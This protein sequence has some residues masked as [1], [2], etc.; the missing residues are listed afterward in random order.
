[1]NLTPEMTTA[2][3]KLIAEIGPILKTMDV[4]TGGQNSYRAVSDKEVKTKVG[5]ALAT[6]GF[7]IFPTKVDATETFLTSKTQY[8]EKQSVFVSVK[9]EY[10]LSHT[11]GGFV[12]LAGYGHG[13][14]SQDKAAGK[15]TTYALKYLLLYLSLAPTGNEEDFPETR[16]DDMPPVTVVPPPKTP[17]P[18]KPDPVKPTPTQA[19]QSFES[20]KPASVQ[21]SPA[22]TP[23][24]AQPAPKPASTDPSTQTQV[25]A[26]PK[27]KY[28]LTVTSEK[29][30]RV[31]EWVIANK[32]L[33]LEKLINGVKANND[34]GDDVVEEIKKQL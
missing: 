29:W 19:V 25:N 13:M 16:P 10:V 33:G 11:S 21:S 17:T 4:P 1:M 24:T 28:Q 34:F 3:G 7:A 2:M 22:P 20:Q 23:A 26:A 31:L 14:D 27:A 9:T 12:T 6:N 18:P 5:Q 32:G 8:G 30:P 15:A